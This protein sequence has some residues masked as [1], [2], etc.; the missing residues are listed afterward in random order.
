MNRGTCWG[1]GA[2]EVDR[3]VSRRCDGLVAWVCAGCVEE[4]A[5]GEIKPASRGSKL[6]AVGVALVVLGA[7]MWVA[8]L[9]ALVS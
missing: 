9:Y 6:L 5:I 1:C 4:A 2:P 3:I 7:C 8:A